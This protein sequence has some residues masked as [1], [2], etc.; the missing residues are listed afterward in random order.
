MKPSLS[1][2]KSLGRGELSERS[3]M[4]EGEV[5]KW[6][7]FYLDTPVKP[8]YDSEEKL[9]YVRKREDGER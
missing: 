7:I 2:P 4:G 3:D 9:E 1:L 5:K 6:M 8:E